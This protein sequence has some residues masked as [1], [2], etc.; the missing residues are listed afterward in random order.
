MPFPEAAIAFG[1]FAPP[2]SASGASAL[3]DPLES[4]PPTPGPPCGCVYDNDPIDQNIPFRHSG[5]QPDRLRVHAALEAAGL[6]DT[7][8][9]A[10]VRCGRSY[11]VLQNRDDPNIYRTVPETCHDR[12]CRP[13]GTDRAARIRRNL[14]SNLGNKPHRFLTL[15]I[16]STYRPLSESIDHLLASFRLLRKTKFWRN[17]VSAG[18]AFLELTYNAD[19][20]LWHPHLHVIAAGKY[21]PRD[22][23]IRAWKRI[24][25]GSFCL[26]IRFVKDHDAT[27]RYIA[28]YATKPLHPSVLR[29][30]DAL[31]E[32]V[33]AMVGRKTLYCFGAWAKWKLLDDPDADSWTVFAPAA[34]LRDK[35]ADGDELCQRILAAITKHPGEEVRVPR[36]PPT[37]PEQSGLCKPENIV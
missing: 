16:R 12:F 19:N 4:T 25:A 30:P 21:I 6:S 35:A 17:R 31:R 1:L 36:A 15:T 27:V 23:L 24:T 2:A 13:C 29:D 34:E 8:R 22:E 37:E 26:D 3:L 33:V 5:W 14:H 32:A 9:T 28:K 18:A 20:R 10:F 7:R 11:W